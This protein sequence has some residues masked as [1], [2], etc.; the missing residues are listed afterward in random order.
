MSLRPIETSGKAMAS[1]ILGL[2]SLRV[3]ACLTG[4]PAIVLGIMGLSDINNPKKRVKGSGMATTGIVLGCL[5]SF[6]FVPVI[7]IALL[8]P[9]VQAARE[10]ARR[11]MCTNNYEANRAGHAQLHNQGR[12]IAAG[13]HVRRQRQAAFELAGPDPAVHGPTELVPDSSISTSRGIVLITSRSPIRCRRL[14]PA[15]R[16]RSAHKLDDRTR[17][18]SIPARFSPESHRVSR[19][20]V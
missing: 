15:R 16:T 19:C 5:T 13:R 2:C 11:A 6:L 20:R 10:A 3:S 1:L 8:L 14:S 4:V 9:A 7:L 18:W 17:W 12:R